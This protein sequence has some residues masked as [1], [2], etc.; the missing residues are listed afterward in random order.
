MSITLRRETPADAGAIDRITRQAFLGHPFSRQTE[1]FI[2]LALRAAGALSL[3]LVAADAGTVV[4]HI[5]FSPVDIDDGSP[6]WYG[7]GPVSVVPERQRQGIGSAL[8]EEG[9]RQLCAQGAQG[10]VLVGDPA[11]YGRFGFAH[12]P[13]LVLD[14]VPQEVFLALPFGPSAARGKVVF[15]AAFAAQG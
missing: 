11:F 2:I 13:A 5:A 4:G 9:L 10:C 7:V 15:H 6:G 1:Q 8:V 12:D 14:G 3:S